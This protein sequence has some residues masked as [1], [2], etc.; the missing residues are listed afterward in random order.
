M[1]KIFIHALKS[2]AIIGIFDWERQVRQTVVVDLEF[3]AKALPPPESMEALIEEFDTLPRPLLIH[4]AAGSDRTGLA[5]ALYTHL[6]E[7]VPLDRAQARHLT[8]R[9]GHWP[10]GRAQAMDRF[11]DLYRQTGDG[12]SLREWVT[13]RYPHIHGELREQDDPETIYS[14]SE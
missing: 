4:C 10:W 11:F 14:A 12:C 2:E 6:Y 9:Y 7:G 3:S 1:D 8:W 13:D 5:C